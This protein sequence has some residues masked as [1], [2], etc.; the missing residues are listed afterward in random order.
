[1]R[2]WA[3]I[4][5]DNLRHN[6]N[7]LK[8]IAGDSTLMP[9]IKANAYGHGMEEIF[10][11]LVSEG[12]N[13]VG[14]ATFNEAENLRK[15]NQSINILIF[16]P[17]ET[18]DMRK[19]IDLNI[20]FPLTS[21]S[22]IDFLNENHLSPRVHIKVD[23]GMGRIGFNMN[24]LDEIR[25]KTGSKS[26]INVEGIFSHLS[27]ADTSSE[28]SKWQLENFKKVIE[29]FPG[30][31]YKH[32][33]NSFG[34]MQFSESKYDIIR[35]GIILYGGVKKENA[36]SYD[37]KPVMTLKAR[38][39]FIKT[40]ENNSFISYNRKYEGKTGEKIATVS[41]G[42]ADGI[43]R[44]LTGKG[45]VFIKNRRCK[46]TGT[47]CMDQLMISIPEDLEVKTGDTVEFFGENIHVEEVAE[48]CGTISYEILCG[49]G[50]R[51]TRLYVGEK[52]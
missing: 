44:D 7:I 21:M 23:T 49:I 14:V 30:I 34:S 2:S 51:V 38:I 41:I 18:E 3:E 9:A 10:N 25:E 1:M 52:Q 29:K 5:L 31:K 48:K 20:A 15:L 16:G 8:K 39:S 6:I 4:N 50:Q 27:S 13:W 43:R 35:P 24:S 12:I 17:V 47:I 22:E 42:Y 32:I 40:L 36:F 45:E 33:L 19:A 46:I 37:F 28:Y 26:K 11:V